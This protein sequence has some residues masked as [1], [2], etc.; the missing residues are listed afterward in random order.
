MYLAAQREAL[1]GGLITGYK[2]KLQFVARTLL[3]Y[4]QTPFRL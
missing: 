2:D 3:S 1:L 4:T